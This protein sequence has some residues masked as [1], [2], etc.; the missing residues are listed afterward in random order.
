[1]TRLAWWADRGAD[2]DERWV[3]A[4]LRPGQRACDIGCGDGRVLA[5]LRR[6]GVAVVGVETD[7]VARG[8][9]HARG[10]DVEAGTAEDLPDRVRADR[11]DVV[12]MVHVLEHCLDPL[13][14][15]ENAVA[16][17]KPGGGKLVIEVPNNEALGLRLAGAAWPWLDV[18]LH[19]NFFTPG[20]LGRACVRAGL[21]V[22]RYEYTGYTRQFGPWWLGLEHQIR[23]TFQGHAT[24]PERR[25]AWRLLVATALRRPR[26]K[27]DS[28]RVICSR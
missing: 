1:L 17:L 23:G 21:R 4:N 7:P 26:W 19:L 28:V 14:G 24:L 8:V 3:H 27:Y 2:V 20:S 6:C 10:L 16:I 13:R 15:L 25:S 9:A 5:A 11:F 12:L 22:E 18:P